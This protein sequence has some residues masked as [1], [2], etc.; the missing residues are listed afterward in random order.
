M[1]EATR[2]ESDTATRRHR[3]QPH[4]ATLDELTAQEARIAGLAGEGLSNPEI[5]ARP[6]ISKGT[7]DYHLNKVFRKL[8]RRVDDE[9]LPAQHLP[10]AVG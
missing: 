1:A 6:Y 8:G 10:R 2:D 4:N 3:A 7:V 9:F 5:A